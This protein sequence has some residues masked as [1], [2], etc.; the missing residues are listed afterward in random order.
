MRPPRSE[1]EQILLWCGVVAQLQRT[2]TNRILR[3]SGLPYP[4]FVLLRH[5]CHD[6]DREWTV[7]QLTAAFETQQPGMTKQVA[8]LEAMSLLAS[9]PDPNDGRSRLLRV[10]RKGVRLR[11]AL[12]AKTEPD[13]ARVFQG[14]KRSE[15]RALHRG[16]DRLRTV[17]DE[18]REDVRL[19]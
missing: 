15:I 13:R 11:D 19:S 2:R 5:F 14:W 8:R 3:D 6:P 12:V 1:E 17:L 4:L 16:L 18:N 10:T 7:G 9:R